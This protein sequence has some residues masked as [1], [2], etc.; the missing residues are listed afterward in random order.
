M[1]S[2]KPKK[3]LIAPEEFVLDKSELIKLFEKVQKHWRRDD[4]NRLQNLEY[5]AV[6]EMTK[7]TIKS[8]DL[9]VL[10]TIWFS[11]N[12]F[13]DEVR[14]LNTL[15]K[16]AMENPKVEKLYTMEW[17]RIDTGA[18]FVENNVM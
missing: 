15:K 13:I 18:A 2:K 16:D 4:F 10:Q 5:A 3:E 6:T 12:F 7:L 1:T 8:T 9:Q 17:N 11:L 14:T